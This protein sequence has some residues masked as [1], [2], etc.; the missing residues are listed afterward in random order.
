MGQIS[1]LLTIMII[2]SVLHRISV[3]DKRFREIK[4]NILCLETFSK[5]RAVEEIKWKNMV[6]SD[7]P[8]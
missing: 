6:E 8:K 1:G 7:T 3:S 4:T 5:N 2:F